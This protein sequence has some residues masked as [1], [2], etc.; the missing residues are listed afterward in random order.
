LG[1]IK[2]QGDADYRYRRTSTETRSLHHH[3]YSLF[4]EA[5]Q[6]EDL[7]TVIDSQFDHD[8]GWTVDHL[9]D[10]AFVKAHGRVRLVEY[11]QSVGLIESFPALLKNFKVIQMRNIQDEATAGRIDAN[12]ATRQRRELNEAEKNAKDMPTQQLSSVGR[13]L[14]AEYQPAMRAICSRSLRATECGV[15]FPAIAF[16]PLAI[17]R[18]VVP[19]E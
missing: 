9:R 7:S 6:D 10:G 14:Y 3:V 18:E 4:E 5:L 12:E 19:T 16:T 15:T 1:L 2:A 13:T 11:T 17:Y 8:R